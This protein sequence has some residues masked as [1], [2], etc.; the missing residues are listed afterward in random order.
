MS[1]AE[2]LDGVRGPHTLSIIGPQRAIVGPSVRTDNGNKGTDKCNKGTDKCNKGTDNGNKGHS[3]LSSG[4][5]SAR[6][7]AAAAPMPPSC[8]MPPTRCAAQRAPTRCAAQRAG[9]LRCAAGADALRCAA[10][11]D[12]L[13]CAAGWLAACRLGG[14]LREGVDAVPVPASIHPWVGCRPDFEAPDA[15]HESEPGGRPARVAVRHARALVA[16]ARLLLLVLPHLTLPAI[17]S[18]VA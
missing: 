10:G 5:P 7:T 18:T 16:L 3:G 15:R 8:G 11:A 6:M 14:T 9:G 12:A 2:R 4:R 1:P 17:A 13:R